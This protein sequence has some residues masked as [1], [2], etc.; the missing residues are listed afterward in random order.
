MTK[1]ICLQQDHPHSDPL[2]L[3][4]ALTDAKKE[5]HIANG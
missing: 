3:C 2:R 4:R 5:A 1:K